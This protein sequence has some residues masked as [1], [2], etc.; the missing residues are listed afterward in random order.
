MTEVN[1]L[2]FIVGKEGIKL[3]QAKIEA[4]KDWPTP[5]TITQV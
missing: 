2:G 3:D 4:I 1:F 5:N